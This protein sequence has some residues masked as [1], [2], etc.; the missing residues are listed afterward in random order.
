MT[1]AVTDSGLG[2]LSTAA[3][4]IRR[5]RAACPFRA[6]HVVYFN[7]HAADGVGYND[8]QST[9]T[10]AALF[11]RALRS[12]HLR[13]QPDHVL[14][15]C[16]T[17]SVLL[18]QTS[19]GAGS[20]S[21]AV[22]IVDAAMRSIL[23][24]LKHRPD[25]AVLLFATP[26][27]V[28]S[29]VYQERLSQA[30]VATQRVG[31][32]SCPRLHS[33][34]EHNP[35]SEVIHSIVYNHVVDG[36][37]QV[38]PLFHHAVAASLNCTHYGYVADVFRAGLQANRVVSPAVLNPNGAMVDFLFENTGTG[39]R[40]EVSVEVISQVPIESQQQRQLGALLGSVSPE[41]AHALRNYSLEKGLFEWRDLCVE[42]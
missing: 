36:L 21:P 38:T 22:G 19:Y 24:Y 17:L 27:T 37:T 20:S 26:T 12:L 6:A 32:V 16:N 42:S 8:L 40:C 34:V 25:C 7:A 5:L 2:G 41:L 23:A 35:T 9:D 3:S 18:N 4:L 13:C 1:I 14:V 29:G 28:S 10:K 11:E 15:A 31:V 30:G 33:L 39:K